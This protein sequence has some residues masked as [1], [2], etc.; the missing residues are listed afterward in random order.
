MA[1]EQGYLVPASE[2]R[3]ELT[4]KK[5]RFIASAGP[6]PTVAAA[7]AFI[8]KLHEEM[9]DA[10]HHAPAYLVGFGNSRIEHC[11]DA[12]EPHGTAG[13]PLLAVLRGSGLGDVVVVVTRY[14]G[15]IKLGTG[16]LVQAYSESAKAV[17][18]EVPVVRKVPLLR[19]QLTLDYK[20]YKPVL[21]LSHDHGARI[22]RQDFSS[23]VQLVLAL[24]LAEWEAFSTSLAELTAG[25]A[26]SVVLGDSTT[27]A[28]G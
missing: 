4:V 7:Q 6:A 12:G 19:V 28:G 24:P 22:D 9:P 13:P 23:G 1:T 25:R 27:L 10:N 16:G 18:K 11:S 20:D 3:I 21:F 15:G 8:A 5:S 14:F 17:L 26:Q 2:L